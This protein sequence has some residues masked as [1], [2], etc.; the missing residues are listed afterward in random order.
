MVNPCKKGGN[1]G[2]KTT[3]LVTVSLTPLLITSIKSL[4]LKILENIFRTGG[5]WPADRELYLKCWPENLNVPIT[6][7]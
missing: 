4:L 3:A 2:L 5:C 7:I 6:Y 1:N